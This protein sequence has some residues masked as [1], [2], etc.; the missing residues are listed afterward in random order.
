MLALLMLCTL[1][2]KDHSVH[3]IDAKT[4]V[5]MKLCLGAIVPYKCDP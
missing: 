4:R 2:F 3:V 1:H 5:P